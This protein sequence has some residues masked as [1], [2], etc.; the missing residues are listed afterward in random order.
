M[1]VMDIVSC[2][3]R[4]MDPPHLNANGEDLEDFVHY[5]GLIWLEDL[6]SAKL[7]WKFQIATFKHLIKF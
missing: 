2:D 5:F 1:I 7:C 6:F 3:T 4:V